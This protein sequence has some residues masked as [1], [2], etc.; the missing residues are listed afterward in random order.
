[1]RRFI[2]TLEVIVTP[3]AVDSA[4]QE[5]RDRI[6]DL[7]RHSLQGRARVLLVE[8]SVMTAEH[9][10]PLNGYHQT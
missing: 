2:V 9:H 10:E 8:R 3:Q 5:V 4:L 6:D 1:M 7:L